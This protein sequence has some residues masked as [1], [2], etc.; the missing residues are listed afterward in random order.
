VGLVNK[1]QWGDPDPT[2]LPYLD[3]NGELVIPHN[4]P[5]KYR[6]WQGGQSVKETLRELQ[7]VRAVTEEKSLP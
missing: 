5:F 2:A 4:C 1:K 6:W 7:S 3:K